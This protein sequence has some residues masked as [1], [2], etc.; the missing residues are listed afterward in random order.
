MAFSK[1]FPKIPLP[2]SH[3]IRNIFHCPYCHKYQCAFTFHLYK[4]LVIF[5]PLEIIR[6]GV[7]G[8]DPWSSYKIT[9]EEVIAGSLFKERLTFSDVRK[10]L[11]VLAKEIQNNVNLQ[12]PHLHWELSKWSIIRFRGFFLVKA[13]TSTE[14]CKTVTII[15]GIIKWPPE[16][17]FVFIFEKISPVVMSAD[18]GFLWRQL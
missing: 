1:F 8:V 11:L 17:E 7:G 13:L 12:N 4:T 14:Y 2:K 5:F 16:L 9:F 6:S 15:C 18:S 3:P 10:G